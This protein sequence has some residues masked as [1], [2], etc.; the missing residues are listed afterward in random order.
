MKSMTPKTS[1]RPPPRGRAARELQP[2]QE[3][4]EEERGVH[5]VWERRIAVMCRFMAPPPSPRSPPARRARRATPPARAPWREVAAEDLAVDRTELPEGRTVGVHV[6]DVPGEAHEMLGSRPAL[7]EDG[8]DVEERLAHLG[9][10]AVG[11]HAGLVP[12]D[13]A[14][15]DDEPAS[16]RHA[17]GVALRLRPARRAAARGGPSPRRSRRPPVLAASSAAIRRSSKR[18][19]LPVLVRGSEAA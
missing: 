17:V 4:D 12:A 19:S 1:V 18:C 13:D 5:G 15:G 2:V 16:R 11:E 3:L 8:A 7:G 6:G 10:E 14:A 9:Q